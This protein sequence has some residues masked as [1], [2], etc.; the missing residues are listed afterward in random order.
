MSYHEVFIR[1][2]QIGGYLLGSERVLEMA[3]NRTQF[4][5]RFGSKN[6]FIALTRSAGELAQWLPLNEAAPSSTQIPF[7]TQGKLLFRF[8]SSFQVLV[9]SLPLV[10]RASRA[11]QYATTVL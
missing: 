11:Q 7:Q 10:G 1:T 2:W 5:N 9:K 4:R 8:W 6:T 3:S